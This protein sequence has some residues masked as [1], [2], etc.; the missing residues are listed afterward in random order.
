MVAVKSSVV[1]VCLGGERERK[2]EKNERWK[3]EK[4]A[5]RREWNGE[6]RGGAGE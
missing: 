4:D 1:V 3:G 2:R 5:R 6:V